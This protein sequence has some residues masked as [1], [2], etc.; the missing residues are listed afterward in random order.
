MPTKLSIIWP[1]LKTHKPVRMDEMVIYRK[2]VSSLASF[3]Q[4]YG[5]LPDE[6]LKSEVI[7]NACLDILLLRRGGKEDK[8]QENFIIST[9]IEV[10]RE[11]APAFDDRYAAIANVGIRQHVEWSG[12]WEFLRTYFREVHQRSI[13]G[14]HE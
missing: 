6:A 4:L 8:A 10:A 7:N 5:A 14:E 2:L 1:S 3:H 13:D 11:I 9:Y 12:M